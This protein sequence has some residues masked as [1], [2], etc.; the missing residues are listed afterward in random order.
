M[1]NNGRETTWQGL[2]ESQAKPKGT[3]MIL[4]NRKAE[5]QAL[6]WRESF[7]PMLIIKVS[8]DWNKQ[9]RPLS[10]CAT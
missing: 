3:G 10:V 5:I 7:A 4:Q 6:Q 1:T 8:K 2:G 9:M